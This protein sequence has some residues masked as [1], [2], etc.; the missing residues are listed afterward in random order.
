MPQENTE[1]E[2]YVPKELREAIEIISSLGL[3]AYI[4]GARSLIIQ[5]IELGRETK[6]WD[7]ILNSPY[8][9]HLRDSL[10]SEFRK[11]RFSVQWRKWG[12]LIEKNKLHIDINY[13]PLTLDQEFEERSKVIH[14]LTLPSLEDLVILKLMSGE[15]K[16]IED[17]KKTLAQAWEKLDKEYIAKR[18]KQAGLEKQ[19]NRLLKRL[20][21][22]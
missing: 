10:T 21:L 12:L 6:N 3:K 5:G 15:R 13:A 11:R 2:I 16:D 19:Y 20:G 22:K 1:E 17:L 18:V 14:G 9:V 4:V 7:L 8:T